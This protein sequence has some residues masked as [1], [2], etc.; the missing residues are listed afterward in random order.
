MMR[1]LRGA[2]VSMASVMASAAT[3]GGCDPAAVSNPASTL[4]SLN[5][6]LSQVDET[7]LDGVLDGLENRT[8]KLAFRRRDAVD[9]DRK[10]GLDPAA[11]TLHTQLLGHSPGDFSSTRDATTPVPRLCAQMTTIINGLG[12]AAAPNAF[13]RAALAF[14]LCEGLDRK[15]DAMLAAGSPLDQ[16]LEDEVAPHMRGTRSDGD[17]K[18]YTI[19]AASV[20]FAVKGVDLTPNLGETR[21]SMRV[22]DPVIKVTEGTYQVS[23]GAGK[24]KVCVDRSLVGATLAIDGR[25]DLT[26]RAQ[27]KEYVRDFAWRTLCGAKYYPYSPPAPETATVPRTLQYGGISISLDTRAEITHID[28]DS[29]GLFIDWAV[30]FALNHT[31]QIRCAIAGVGKDACE[32]STEAARTIAVASY[33]LTLPQWGAVLEHLRWEAVN[34]VQRFRFDSRTGLDPDGDLIFTG[35]DNCPNNANPDQLDSD[36]DGVGEVCD[37][38]TAPPAELRDRLILHQTKHCDGFTVSEKLHSLRTDAAIDRIT[39]QT[40]VQAATDYWKQQTVDYGF[41]WSWVVIDEKPDRMF[42]TADIALAMAKQNLDIL[43]TRWNIA[44][45]RVLPLKLIKVGSVRRVV[46]DPVAPLPKLTDYQ[47]GVL[48]LAIPDRLVP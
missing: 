23:Q 35:L 2:M 6:G 48:E 41:D 11:S 34:S 42:A 12:T 21:L 17:C 27:A 13:A 7:T 5:N 29:Q 4:Q 25:L 24:N 20:E 28:L 30:Q 22:E 14:M 19:A 26:F 38:R 45:L 9:T 15:L 31:K 3:A 44:A 39:T 1:T 16:F 8:Y 33:D 37:P 47:R 32:R 46:I 40:M 43:A 18:G 10:G 36:S